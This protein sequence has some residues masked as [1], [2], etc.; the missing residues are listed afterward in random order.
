MKE[1][2]ITVEDHMLALELKDAVTL[3]RHISILTDKQNTDTNDLFKTIS[4]VN[5]TVNDFLR[6]R[7]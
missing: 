5:C 4:L 3:I 6:K 2:E 7:G 1:V